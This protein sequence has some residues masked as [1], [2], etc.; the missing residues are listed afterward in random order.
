MAEFL[1]KVKAIVRPDKFKRVGI[2][3]IIFVD[4]ISILWLLMPS[5]FGELF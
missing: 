5:F 1:A 2:F 4:L 3:E